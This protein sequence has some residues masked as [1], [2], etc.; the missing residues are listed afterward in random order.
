MK[1]AEKN[2]MDP[3]IWDGSVAEWVLKKAEPKYYNDS[4]VKYGYFTGKES[5]AFVSKILERYEHYRNILPDNGESLTFNTSG[6][7]A[8]K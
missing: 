8:H 1:L 6:G 5:V 4:V 7:T 3:Q 2:G